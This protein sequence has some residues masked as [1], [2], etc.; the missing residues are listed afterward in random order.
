[1]EENSY[2]LHHMKGDTWTS[3]DVNDVPGRRKNESWRAKN[4][5]NPMKYACFRFGRVDHL[6]N[7]CHQL[8][9][10]VALN[11]VVSVVCKTKMLLINGQTKW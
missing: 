7:D 4:Y 6:L 8:E 1:M 9:K 2:Q 10:K 11:V 3:I 5:D